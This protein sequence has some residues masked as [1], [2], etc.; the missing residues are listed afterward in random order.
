MR[1][2]RR[3]RRWWASLCRLGAAAVLVAGGALIVA[4]PAG[5]QAPPPKCTP[6]PNSTVSAKDVVNCLQTVAIDATDLTVTGSIDLTALGTV[7]HPIRCH[8]CHLQGDLKIA[9]VSFTRAI[10]FDGVLIDGNLDARGATFQAPVLARAEPSVPSG[11]TGT[12][13]FSL[14]TFADAVTFDALSFGKSANFD[15]ARFESSVSFEG[16]QFAA[17]AQFERIEV[18]GFFVL[19]GPGAV[20]QETSLR[21]G[22]FHGT[23]DLE[24]R[25][26]VGG[27]NGSGAD[28][29]GRTN[30]SRATVGK[31][32]DSAGLVLDGASFADVDASGA[33]FASHA[34]LQLAHASA[35]NLNQTVALAGLSL[36]GTQIDGPASFDGAQLQGALDLQKFAATQ[37]VLDIGALGNVASGPARR[38]ILSKIERTARDAGDIQLANDARFRLLQVDGRN[39]SFPKREVDWV[40]YEQ[41]GGYLVR[42]L[43]PLRA[44]FVLILVGTAARY[45]VDWR[46]ER[47]GQV[48]VAGHDLAA[49]T[50]RVRVGHEVTGFLER[51]SRAVIASLR[52]KPN[53]ASPVGETTVEP[54]VIAGLRLCEYVASKLLIVVFF[55]SLGNYN[56]T[57][58][59]VLGSVKL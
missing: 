28:F 47:T 54:Y 15:G 45:V 26:F 34:S 48:A 38:S 24:A 9:D 55:L 43:R 14:A 44:L 53:I 59:D 4:A 17:D 56:A 6:M 31:T 12:A 21:D 51:F 32:A 23:V 46:R 22:V 29:I 1:Q 20:Q 25:Q 7:D 3:G 16:A 39:S 42:P 40:F 11:V 50:S 41:L 27:L 35:L 2:R 5:A 52:P 36:Q 37:I 33:T 13:D 8:R 49:M 57:L 58:R 19:S 30:L 18:D 10:D